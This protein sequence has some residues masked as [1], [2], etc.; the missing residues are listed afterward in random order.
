[1]SAN[2][3]YIVR[4]NDC[5]FVSEVLLDEKRALNERDFH[6]LERLHSVSIWSY[7]GESWTLVTELLGVSL[8]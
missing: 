2:C 6:A 1:M 4:C 8:H 5:E 7:S 3:P